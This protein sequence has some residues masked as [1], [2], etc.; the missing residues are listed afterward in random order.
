MKILSDFAFE[1]KKVLMRCDFD[2]PL[3][4]KGN[5][6][7]DF[8]IERSISTI[9]Y[10]VKK[11]AKLIL[12]CHLKGFDGEI[13]S[14]API[15]K[16]LTEYL[17]F[18]ITKAKNCVGKEIED[19][20]LQMSPGEILLLENLRLHTGEKENDQEFAKDLAKLGDIYI[21]EAFATCHRKHAS[22]VGVPKYLPSAAGLVLME[23][24]RVLSEIRKNPARPLVAIMGG[25][26]QEKKGLIFVE[27]M[28]QVADFVLIGGLIKKAIEKE[29]FSF[30]SPQKIIFPIKEAVS[31][32]DLGPKTL[33]IFKE[34][35]SQAKTI[36]WSGPVGKI[37]EKRFSKGTM[38]IAMAIISAS[39]FKVAGGGATIDFLRDHNL[40]SKFNHLST[41]GGSALAFLA[42]EKLPGIEALK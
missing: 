13:V 19:W 10:L 41:G 31:D 38:E 42:G 34:K 35:I 1:N 18:S 14:V 7:D 32:F 9:V 39:A 8:R 4:E 25:T 16:K 2:V 33:K 3:D 21:N 28:S 37:E 23:E 20:I 26:V 11:N 30:T 15:R 24:I 22:I 5:I 36:F 17:D 40:A 6:L 12:M 29:R 27:R